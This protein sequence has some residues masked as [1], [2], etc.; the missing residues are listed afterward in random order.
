MLRRK[1]KLVVGGDKPLQ[2]KII[3]LMHN[4]V[5]G[6]HSG[7]QATVKRL[8][9]TFY[10]HGMEKDVRNFIRQCATCQTS[11]YNPTKPVGLL[12]PLPIPASLWSDISMDFIEGFPKSNDKDVVLVVVVRLSMYAYFMSLKHPYIT[13]DVVVLFLNNVFKPHGLPSLMVSDRDPIFVISFRTEL[14]TLQGVEFLRSAAHHPQ[15]DGQSEVVNR[16]LETYLRCMTHGHPKKWEAWLSLVE[17][18]YNTNY[19]SSLQSTPFGALYGIPPPIHIPYILRD[20]SVSSL[21]QLLL[22]REEA[23]LAPK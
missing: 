16:C 5:E 3:G 22:D 10:W 17:W 2:N 11:K 8:Q 13:Y 23:L 14:F 1:R 4:S 7:V 12:Q 21:E 19:H 6:G 18:W 15:T 9:L 20:S